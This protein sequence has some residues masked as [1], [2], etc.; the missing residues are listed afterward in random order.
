MRKG[1]IKKPHQIQQKKPNVFISTIW[2][3]LE[4]IVVIIALPF[5]I[6]YTLWNDWRNNSSSESDLLKN[7]SYKNEHEYCVGL[8]KCKFCLRAAAIVDKYDR[9]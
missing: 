7:Q 4:D 9:N 3:F 1:K 6:T 8:A 2:D 5:V